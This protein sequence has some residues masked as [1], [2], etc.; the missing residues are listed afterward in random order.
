MSLAAMDG[1][2]LNCDSFDDGAV[3]A[4]CPEALGR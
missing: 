2:G 4:S 3:N 1:F